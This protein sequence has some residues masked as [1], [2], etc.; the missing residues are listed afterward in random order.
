MQ[1]VEEERKGIRI[2]IMAWTH[3]DKNGHY[4]SGSLSLL[5]S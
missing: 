2:K 1:K 5:P 3:R 4:R